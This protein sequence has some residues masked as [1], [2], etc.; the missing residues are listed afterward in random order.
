MLDREL[1]AELDEAS[2]KVP[3]T[4]RLSAEDAASYVA[5]LAEVFVVDPT[6]IYWWESLKGS[7]SRIPYGNGDGLSRLEEVLGDYKDVRL[8]VTDDQEPP[9]PVY[10]GSALQLVALLRECRFCEF[11]MAAQDTSWV[12]FDTHMN[13]LVIVGLGV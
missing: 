5:S 3:G 6:S 10:A 1:L 2:R 7:T 11:M 4:R 9:W 13:E 12:I 8:V